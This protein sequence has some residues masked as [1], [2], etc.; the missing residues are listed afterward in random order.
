MAGIIITMLL[1]AGF[2]AY[3]QHSVQCIVKQK[4]GIDCAGC[5]LTRGFYNILHGN[6]KE[7]NS[8]NTNAV[9]IFSFFAIEL[10][11]RLVLIV[12]SGI[13]RLNVSR[14]IIWDILQAITLFFLCFY[15]YIK[16]LFE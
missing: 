5:G 16:Y 8:L 7:A 4:T 2:F 3:N 10:L 1:Y 14:F 13:K 11:I 9:F 6:I 12:A 15:P